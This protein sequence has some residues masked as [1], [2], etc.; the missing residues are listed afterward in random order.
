LYSILQASIT[1]FVHRQADYNVAIISRWIEPADA[2]RTID[3]APR[4]YR[5]QV[6]RQR[7]VRDLPQI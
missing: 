6:V 1:A 4:A 7:N 2:E 5:D 3:W